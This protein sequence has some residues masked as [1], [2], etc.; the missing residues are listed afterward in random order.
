MTLQVGDVIRVATTGTAPQTS[1]FQ[2]VWHYKMTAGAGCAEN[3][4]LAG[5][6]AQYAQAWDEMDAL[7]SDQYQVNLIEAWTRDPALQTWNGIGQISAGPLVGLSIGD[8]EAHGVA[9][10]GLI[11]TELARRQGRHFLP[12]VS[13]AQLDLG[14]W[15]AGCLVAFALYLAEFVQTL[16]LTGGTFTWCTYNDTPGSKYE[17]SAS[18]YDGTVIINEI[19]GYQR[20]RKPLVGI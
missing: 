9:I 6:V 5:V 3:V 20:R 2:N 10:V 1:V 17:E 12:G 4:F 13:D 16:S 7:I 19:A 18:L 14:L 15:E 8:P 11:V